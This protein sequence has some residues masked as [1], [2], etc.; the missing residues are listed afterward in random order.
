MILVVRGRVR[1]VA[2][3]NNGVV[4]ISCE[5][6]RAVPRFHRDCV[7]GVEGRGVWHFDIAIGTIE[8]KSLLDLTVSECDPAI[9][10]SVV[11][12]DKIIGITLSSPPGDQTCRCRDAVLGGGDCGLNQGGEYECHTQLEKAPLSL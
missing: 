5:G 12:A 1:S 9:N 8:K 6:N 11:R 7:P 2:L 10:H 3:V 4:A